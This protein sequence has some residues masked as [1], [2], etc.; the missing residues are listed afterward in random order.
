M[1]LS[2]MQTPKAEVHNVRVPAI[3]LVC[4]SNMPRATAYRRLWTFPIC[5]QPTV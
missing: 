5:S 4:A 1:I 2:E 3:N